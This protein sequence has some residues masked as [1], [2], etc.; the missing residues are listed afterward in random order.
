MATT[1]VIGL[2]AG[3]R[4]L[5]ST[6]YYSDLAEKLSSS[7]DLGFSHHQVTSSKNVINA[8]RSSNYS[9]NF[10]SSRDA[11]SIKAVKE[12]VDTASSPSNVEPWIQ[13]SNHLEDEI[14]NPE[15]SVDALLLLQKSMLEK[16]WNLTTEETLIASTS[17]ET[18]K[19]MQV[20][21]S[22]TSARRRRIDTRRR[23]VNQRSYHMQL[24]TN[25]QQASVI[26]PNLLQNHLKSY[27]KGVISEEL[28][29]HT[30][31]V[32]LSKIIKTGLHI[33][34]RKAR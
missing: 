19:K 1:A 30:E 14:D 17:R 20:T 15:F 5:S 7:S 31:V 24:S 34:D 32:Q 9:P 10:L 3:K 28:L 26:S 6:F 11:Q 29:T 22:G 27:V 18:R 12:H 33:E 2:S 4:L 23:V 13:S 25:K 8:K 16:Q 21:G